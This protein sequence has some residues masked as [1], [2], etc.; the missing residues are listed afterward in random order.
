M[1]KLRHC[2]H[3]CMRTLFY[4]APLLQPKQ[5]QKYPTFDLG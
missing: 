5:S 4:N 1:K 2:R 3:I